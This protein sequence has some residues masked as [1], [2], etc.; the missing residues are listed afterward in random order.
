M[1]QQMTL[2]EIF[3]F[4]QDTADQIE[5]SSQISEIER[6]ASVLSAIEKTEEQSFTFT[7]GTVDAYMG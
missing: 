1:T 5:E 7:S 6:H 3:S 2:E 4:I